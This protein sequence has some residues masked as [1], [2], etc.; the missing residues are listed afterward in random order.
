MTKCQL[1]CIIFREAGIKPT[2]LCSPGYWETSL[3]VAKLDG[4]LF[5]LLWSEVF[6]HSKSSY[7]VLTFPVPTHQ[8]TYHE[9]D[10]PKM[11]Q[12]WT[13]TLATRLHFQEIC[14]GNWDKKIKLSW[15]RD[16]NLLSYSKSSLGEVICLFFSPNT[17]TI[18][19]FPLANLKERISRLTLF[20]L[21]V[22]GP[23]LFPPTTSL[24]NW[25]AVSVG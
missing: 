6:S 11:N 22:R 14:I 1:F 21:A 15:P 7:K 3:A 10:A 20:L 4:L 9:T 18:W 13:H 8:N 12:V 17:E 19:Y 24:Q 16:S 25:S 5:I 2:L 23:K